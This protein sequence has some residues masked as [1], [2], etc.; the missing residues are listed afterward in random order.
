[1]V[2]LTLDMG[3][4]CNN[5]CKFCAADGPRPVD[6]D[7]PE[8][9]SFIGSAGGKLG[10]VSLGGGEPTV[11]KNLFLIIK[12]LRERYGADVNMLT[13]ARLFSNKAFLGKVVESGIFNVCASIYGCTPEMHDRQTQRPGSFWETYV[14]IRNLSCSG[15]P[16]EVRTLIT[17][18]TFR[19]LPELARFIIL[20]FPGAYQY[21]ISGLDISR[22][23]VKNE[24]EVSVRFS[25]AA[26]HVERAI[27][28]GRF[29]G[30]ELKI[31]SFPLCLLGEAYRSN[32]PALYSHDLLLSPS[33]LVEQDIGRHRCIF[34]CRLKDKCPGAYE[35]YWIRYGYGELKPVL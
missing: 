16:F 13:N 20:N 5:D 10:V 34:E 4:R 27:D 3:F 2:S 12:L 29:L 22:S 8:I 35:K 28:A 33:G 17:K 11:Q 30:V 15:I 6:M 1:L 18:K 31:F 21:G 26:P 24:S 7:I 32:V 19:H 14:G 9:M 23:V 25:E